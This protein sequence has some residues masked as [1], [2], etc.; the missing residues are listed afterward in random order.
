MDYHILGG[1]LSVKV[2]KRDGRAVDFDRG[3]IV[4]AILSAMNAAKTVNVSFAEQLATNICRHISDENYGCVS[5]E[6]IQDL[7][8]E[9]MMSSEYKEAARAFILYRDKRNK[10]RCSES[11][12]VIRS[13]VNAESNEVTKENANM[14]AAS[15]A[16]MMAKIASERSKEYA[17]N[18]LLTEEAMKF[19]NDNLVHVHDLDWLSTGSL[20]CA[21]SR[22]NVTIKDGNGN[23][24]HVQLSWF[25]Q[26]YSN[27]EATESPV[28]VKPD[29]FIWILGRNG[30]TRITGVSRRLLSAKDSLYNIKTHKGIGIELTGTHLVPVIDK[31]S[32]NETLKDVESIQVGDQMIKPACFDVAEA[33]SDYIDVVKLILDSKEIAKKDIVVC[34]IL[35]LR[36]WLRYRYGIKSLAE[37]LRSTTYRHGITYIT[38]DEYTHILDKF[39]VP[40]DV[41]QS[42]DVHC[43]H[44]KD[45]LPMYLPISPE[46]AMIC[47]YLHSDGSV[48]CIPQTGNYQ[49]AFTGFNP[50][51]NDRFKEVFQKVFPNHLSVRKAEGKYAGWL[52]SSKLLSN[53]FKHALGMHCGSLRLQIPDFVMHGSSEIKWSYL[54][55]VID[56]DG[57]IASS[58]GRQVSI[59]TSC[60]RFANQIMLLLSSLGVDSSLQE[61]CDKGTKVRFSNGYVSTRKENCRK[62]VITGYENIKT[63]LENING[64]KQNSI[65]AFYAAK[66]SK[67]MQ[68]AP[69]TVMSKTPMDPEGE[70]VYDLET[71]EHWWIG[72]DYVLHNCIQHPMDK[73]LKHGFIAGHGESR[74]AKRIE[75]ASILCAISLET[76]QNLMHGGQAIPAF[77][78][79]L[80][81][82]VRST[83]IE[84]L[85]K[86]GIVA[87]VDLSYYNHMQIDDYLTKPLGNLLGDNRLIQIA[88]NE[89]VHRVHQA[90][91]AFV[92]NM[93]T[94]HS[95]Q[96][97]QVVFS[98]VNYGTD[99]SAEGRCVIRELLVTTERG[100]G[101]GSTAI[102]PIQIM[103]LKQGIN[104]KPED[105]NYDLYQLACRVTAKRFFPN[106]LNLDATFNKDEA[107]K[108]DDP[109]R[110]EHEVATMGCVDGDEIVTYRIDGHLHVV[111]IRKFWDCMSKLFDVKDASG[112]GYNLGQFIDL[113]NVEI[114]DINGFVPCHRLIRNPDKSDWM[115]VTLTNGRVITV[116]SDHPWSV[117]GK[118]VVPTK[119]LRTS[120]KI[121]LSTSQSVN[122]RYNLCSQD[123]AW[124][125]GF[126]LCDGCYA[127]SMTSYIGMDEGDIA[128]KYCRVFKN[129]VGSITHIHEQHRGEKGDYIELKNY[130]S[131][132]GSVTKFRWSLHADFG[133]L[134]K[135]HRNVPNWVFE[136]DAKVRVAFLAGMM[137]ADGYISSQR[138]RAK[139]QIGSTNKALALQTMLLAQSLGVPAKVYENHYNALK[140]EK[141]RYRVEF[142][143]FEELLAHMAS[144]KKKSH[145]TEFFE[146]IDF[147]CGAIS[148]IEFIGPRGEFSYDV[149]TAS[150]HFIV[151]GIRSHNCRT[152]VY[153]NRHGEKCSI[154]RGNLSFTT[155]NLPG[156]A[157]SVMNIDNEEDRIS[158]FYTKL[159][160]ALKVT[161]QQLYDR[162][163]YQS[164]AKA[165]QFP[166]LM[167]G[168]WKDSDKLGAEDEVRPVLKHGTLG[169]GFIGLAECLIALVGKHHGESDKAQELGLQII[170]HMKAFAD[171]EANERDLNYSIL[172]TPAE[173]LSGK[174]T[175]K[176]KKKFGIIPGI[177]DKDYYTNS[178]HV[179]VYYHCSATHKAKI[180]GPYHELTRGGHIF[181]VELDGDAT[182]NVQAIDDIVKLMDKHNIGYC[183]VNHNRNRCMK[184]GYEDAQKELKECPL[185][186][187]DCIDTIQRI[188]GYLVGATSSWNAGKLAELND[189]VTHD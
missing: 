115:R 124:L 2:L 136:S 175:K 183:S 147:N 125:K 70:V 172:A 57:C 171:N 38:L 78:Y 137:D 144:E 155:I 54:S 86:V 168:M 109:K 185:C 32:K 186:G 39:E 79:Y 173:G 116:T 95:R 88:I 27:Q 146:P 60:R 87:G 47:G 100:I 11:D 189:R 150:E 145:A 18:Y 97:N 44:G 50:E 3:R 162:Y 21:T 64:V 107:W 130:A 96:G 93:N 35:Q 10:A 118:G 65:D 99:T 28:W 52:F 29:K 31:D 6:K 41:I 182:H 8:E 83:F 37:Y 62:I 104:K 71:V 33:S 20:T 129:E 169:I 76:I 72:N 68:Y 25:D 92:H 181:Y 91:E 1:C 132:E 73:L 102:F 143:A 58:G 158:A 119:S 16:G 46:L 135:T 5:V 140:P 165:K 12:E 43:L 188:T 80:A 24:K 51:I 67:A 94:I 133:A 187:S 161:A 112:Y 36:E 113:E 84:E 55:A 74:P 178:N 148:K 170:R 30:W 121:T 139:C 141:V 40:L 131:G 167:A 114:E 15:P 90:M 153:E 174:F 53:F 120:D 34:N 81:P 56:G 82:F 176:D 77:D 156:L 152:R 108:E 122:G 159:D 177:T 134:K 166:L 48:T 110:Y 142:D 63:L 123:M 23:I 17:E 14:N 179:P 106:F 163:L 180:E 154:G 89:T 85:K 127:N 42:M 164:Q 9:A 75:T 19:K 101:N 22:T 105:R 138:D 160:E 59:A 26:F 4:K 151:S 69:M 49:I 7:I 111:P 45:F 128:E 98:S 149:T 184:C 103:K 13:I 61:K 66:P 126:I 157:M 117:I